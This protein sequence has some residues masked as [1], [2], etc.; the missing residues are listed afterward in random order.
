MK[1]LERLFLYLLSPHVCH[2][3]DLLQF[4]YQEIVAVKDTILYLLHRAHSHLN[5]GSG[6]VRF[7][8]FDFSVVFYTIQPLILRDKLLQMRVDQCLVS[9]I[10]DY[11]S[12]RPQYVRLKSCISDTVVSSAGPNWEKF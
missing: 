4:S 2:A 10:T 12:E 8:F 7:M 6:V 3:I 11:L 5:K 1:T 9:W